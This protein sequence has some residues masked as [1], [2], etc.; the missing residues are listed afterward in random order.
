[1]DPKLRER[2]TV[3]APRE[4]AGEVVSE[5]RTESPH[6]MRASR[7]RRFPRDNRERHRRKAP[8]PNERAYDVCEDRW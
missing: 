8:V 4:D 3:E 5:L 1:M 7:R 6:L 2:R